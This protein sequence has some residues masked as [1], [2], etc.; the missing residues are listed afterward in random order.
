MLPLT[1]HIDRRHFWCPACRVVVAYF[2]RVVCRAPRDAGE[3][4]SLR[5]RIHTLAR[6]KSYLSPR[7]HC[8]GFALAYVRALPRLKPPQ[9]R[10]GVVVAVQ[11]HAVAKRH[12]SRHGER[13][14]E[15]VCHVSTQVG[16]LKP[17]TEV[18]RNEG[19]TARATIQP[20]SVSGSGLPRHDARSVRRG[21]HI[22]VRTR[23]RSGDESRLGE[24][25]A[26]DARAATLLDD[27]DSRTQP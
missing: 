5:L 11:L 22:D 6:N 2:T 27:L 25:R 7:S 17:K 23:Q 1:R 4:V 26:S 12:R 20:L 21:L 8:T 24:A 15:A 9:R 3:D 18:P 19:T 13:T 10:L 14:A 16:S